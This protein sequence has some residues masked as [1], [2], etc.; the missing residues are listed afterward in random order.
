[1][2]VKKNCNYSHYV[3]I[4]FSIYL[5]N[6][7]TIHNYFEKISLFKAYNNNL[8]FFIISSAAVRSQMRRI[9]HHK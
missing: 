1:M 3:N 2:I 8:K 7:Y 9:D 6:N 5:L 4:V